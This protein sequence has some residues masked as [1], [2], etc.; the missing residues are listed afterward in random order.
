MLKPSPDP[1][2]RAIGIFILLAF[3]ACLVLREDGL[4]DNSF[5]ELQ[6]ELTVYDEN[7]H[8]VLRSK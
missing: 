6:S 5:Q 3:M 4:T 2:A 8:R 7:G 1:V